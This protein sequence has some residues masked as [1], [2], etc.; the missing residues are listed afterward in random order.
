[1]NGKQRLFSISRFRSRTLSFLFLSAQMEGIRRRFFFFLFSLPAK[2][3]RPLPPPF[4]L[5]FF[6]RFEEK[7]R[8]CLPPFFF[9]APFSFGREEEDE[10][11]PTF[12]SLFPLIYH[13][14]SAPFSLPPRSSFWEDG[15]EVLPFFLHAASTFFSSYRN[16][17]TTG[18]PFPRGPKDFFFIDNGGGS[19]PPPLPDFRNLLLFF[20]WECP[21]KGC[22]RFGV[23]SSFFFFLTPEKIA[24]P[25]LLFPLGS[26]GRRGRRQLLHFFPSPGH[27][28]TIYL[29]SPPSPSILGRGMRVRILITPMEEISS[30]PPCERRGEGGGGCALFSS[31]GFFLSAGTRNK[32][33][34]PPPF[35]WRRGLPFSPLPREESF[36]LPEKVRSFSRRQDRFPTGWYLP[37]FP[38]LSQS[39]H[40]V[41]FSPPFFFLTVRDDFP[42][43]WSFS[44]PLHPMTAASPFCIQKKER[45]FSPFFPLCSAVS[46]LLLIVGS[47]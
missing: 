7:R 37:A 5:L 29:P 41:R 24:T 11:R 9:L 23:V 46:P 38:P 13:P 3:K 47:K 43:K 19:F 4:S 26:P 39:W 36:P 44:P 27:S 2:S 15:F 31:P 42:Q 25:S 33:Y 14:G 45:S 32:T 35:F 17:A 1:L 10:V 21:K 34:T 8:V 20:Y 22:C 6:P 30:P 12:F 40:R 16:M 28:L 18:Y